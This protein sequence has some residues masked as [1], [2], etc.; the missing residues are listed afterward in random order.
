M[1]KTHTDTCEA[2]DRRTSSICST[3]SFREGAGRRAGRVVIWSKCQ[4]CESSGAKFL[5]V[6]IIQA[7][8]QRRFQV[9]NTSE[10]KRLL[11][12]SLLN[13]FRR[14]KEEDETALLT[15]QK[16]ISVSVSVSSLRW[17]SEPSSSVP[18]KE[19]PQ[20]LEEPFSIVCGTFSVFQPDHRERHGMGFRHRRL[21]TLFFERVCHEIK[22][23]RLEVLYCT[24]PCE[25]RFGK[26]GQLH[27]S[28]T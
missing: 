22:Q 14:K 1:M 8:S 28:R 13:S 10:E 18:E 20:P 3:C 19:A 15:F 21:L 26:E 4:V 27:P 6:S 17:F 24:C 25:I 2:R 11:A 23:L 16:K 7:P 5:L 9:K 12:R